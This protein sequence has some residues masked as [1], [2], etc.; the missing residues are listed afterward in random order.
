MCNILSGC[1]SE[2]IGFGVG[3]E[4]Y[5]VGGCAIMRYRGSCC[6]CLD[7]CVTIDSSGQ[8]EPSIV[9]TNFEMTD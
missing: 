7:V 3:L 2:V 6:E 4:Y 5:V 9:S 1:I 8:P